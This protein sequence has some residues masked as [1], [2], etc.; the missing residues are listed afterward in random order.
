MC[1]KQGQKPYFVREEERYHL[2]P[3]KDDGN[4]FSDLAAT[5]FCTKTP[6]S[7]LTRKKIE[8]LLQDDV[9]KELKNTLSGK[10]Y[11][12]RRASRHRK[13]IQADSSS[14]IISNK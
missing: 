4:V 3:S 10:A 9:I 6:A 7:G 8:V 11:H 14:S 2:S 5:L 13:D 12:Y 1:I